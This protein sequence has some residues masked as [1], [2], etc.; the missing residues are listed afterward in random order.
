MGIESDKSFVAVFTM[1][2]FLLFFVMP[3]FIM[4]VLVQEIQEVVSLT[5]IHKVWF[6]S[7]WLF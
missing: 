3:F 6:G 1:V 5:L 2:L 4:F 7:F